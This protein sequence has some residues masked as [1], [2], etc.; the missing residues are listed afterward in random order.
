MTTIDES[1]ET[2]HA[3]SP[4]HWAAIAGTVV[5]AF[6]LAAVRR[7]VRGEPGRARRLDVTLAALATVAW[8]VT[9]VFQMTRDEFPARTALPL[10]WSDLIALA[11]PVALYTQWR[12]VRAVVYFWGL[13]LGMLA[14]LMPDLRVGP[15]R[16][17]YW[18]FWVAHMIIFAGIVYELV[19]RDLRP[20]WRDLGRAVA[21]AVVYGMLI[22]PF[23][24]VTGYGYGYLGPDHAEQPAAL[25]YFGRWPWRLAPLALTGAAVMAGLTVPW[26]VGRRGSG[27][28]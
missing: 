5:I 24:A 13:A 3:W 19:G 7:R 21:A 11:V 18:L 14:F 6:A 9:Q 1:L 27:A 25:A 20:G 15:A 4:S 26:V 28:R 8:I 2:F 23:N 12:W 10:H 17:G 16:L 22:V